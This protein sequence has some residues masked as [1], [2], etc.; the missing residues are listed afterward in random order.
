MEDATAS[1]RPGTENAPFFAGLADQQSS[2]GKNVMP[3]YDYDCANCGAF[4]AVRRIAERDDPVACPH[5]GA[6]A[7][8]MTIAAPSVGGAS[9]FGDG[10]GDAGSYGMSHRGGC[11]CCR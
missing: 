1:T 4:E 6:P 11:F 3:I 5:C 8:R 2:S 7:A 9:S 10:A